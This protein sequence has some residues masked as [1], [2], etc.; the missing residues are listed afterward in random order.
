MLN[1]K[2]S[3]QRHTM[4]R[5]NSVCNRF[6]RRKRSEEIDEKDE[7]DEIQASAAYKERLKGSIAIATISNSCSCSS[8][9]VCKSGDNKK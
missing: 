8:S 9:C 4:N 2:M 5:G 3:K 6:S 1:Y 7:N